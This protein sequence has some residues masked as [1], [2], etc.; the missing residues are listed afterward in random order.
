[1][2]AKTHEWEP[3]SA[4]CPAEERL[5]CPTL[6]QIA[7][8][9]V[10]ESLVPTLNKSEFVVELNLSLV[11]DHHTLRLSP[12]PEG[13]PCP[14]ASWD[15][16]LHQDGLVRLTWDQY[17]SA[18]RQRCWLRDSRPRPEAGCSGVHHFEWSKLALF[19]FLLQVMQSV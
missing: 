13:R 17:Q 11:P 7:E 12:S 6:L 1:M 3:L 9:C 18:L 16:T 14:V 5:C 2:S 10:P 19:D 8:H 15:K 4:P